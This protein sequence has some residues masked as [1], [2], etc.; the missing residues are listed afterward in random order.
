[1]KNILCGLVVVVLG[2]QLLSVAVF[3]S[4][5]YAYVATTKGAPSDWE[6]INCYFGALR[7]D[8]S[9]MVNMIPGG[10]GGKVFRLSGSVKV[11]SGGKVLGFNALDNGMPIVLILSKQKVVDEIRINQTGGN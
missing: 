1:M 5:S 4:P 3:E 10:A 11:T 9:I 8:N 2:C 6:V 7:K